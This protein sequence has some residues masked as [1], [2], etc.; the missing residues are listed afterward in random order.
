ML[1]FLGGLSDGEASRG[2]S[3]GR[4]SRRDDPRRHTL[5]GNHL[6]VHP[7]H[8][9]PGQHNTLDMEVS[10]CTNSQVSGVFELQHIWQ[11]LIPLYYVYRKSSLQIVYTFVQYIV[12]LSN[13]FFQRNSLLFQM[14]A[15][16]TYHLIIWFPTFHV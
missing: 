7:H 9:I 2:P 4:S 3:R 8:S 13:L 15:Y 16:I 14:T 10:Y 1:W 12:K 11:E 5:A 6:Y